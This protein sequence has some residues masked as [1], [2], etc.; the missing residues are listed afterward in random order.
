MIISVS[1]IPH[2]Q[3][4]D[5]KSS[6]KTQHNDAQNTIALARDRQ[7]NRYGSSTKNNSSLTN[8]D[9]K[10]FVT[11]A[12][13]TKVFLDSAATKLKLSARSYFKVIKVAQTIA[14]LENSQ[15][16]ETSHLAEA[17]QYRQIS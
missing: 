17:L 11:L 13:P 10:R 14:D 4:L 2:D 3:L 16:I 5:T 1:R 9:V 8:G 7:I 12:P 15:T 6:Q